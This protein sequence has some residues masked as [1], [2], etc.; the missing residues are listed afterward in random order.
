MLSNKTKLVDFH[1]HYDLLPT[2][3]REPGAQL[4]DVTI[5]GVTT[6][7]LAWL[8]NLKV[9]GTVDRIIPALGMHPQLISSRAKDFEKFSYYVEDS[10]IIGEVGLDGSKNFSDS[11]PTQEKIFSNILS[12]CNSENPKVLSIH[13][14]KA[15]S[16]VISHLKEHTNSS[17]VTPIMHWFT[18]SVTQASKLLDMGAKFSFNHK[19]LKTKSGQKLLMYLPR[20]SVLTET[21]LPFT[22]KSYSPELHRDLL[23][24][25]VDMIASFW[26]T[27]LEDCTEHL[28]KNANI[29]L[30]EK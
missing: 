11:L 20:D 21:D 16:K 22:S 2:F 3:G 28:L 30:R 12:M 19:M 24:N 13:S 15:E 17:S 25:S 9:S 18:G 10:R 26:D 4:S 7:P 27:S 8:K 14:L 23:V 29:V 1:C 5:L 6:T